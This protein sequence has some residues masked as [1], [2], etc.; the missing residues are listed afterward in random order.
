MKEF[1]LIRE[2]WRF[3]IKKNFFTSSQL[4]LF[5]TKISLLGSERISRTSEVH[6]ISIKQPTMLVIELKT[7]S[8]RKSIPL[9]FERDLKLCNANRGNH[10]KSRQISFNV[11][12]AWAWR[13]SCECNYRSLSAQL[14]DCSVWDKNHLF[15][16]FMLLKLLPFKSTLI[17]IGL[18][19]SSKHKKSILKSE[20][21]DQTK[22]QRFSI[23]LQT[24]IFNYSWKAF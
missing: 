11:T 20:S 3:L 5:T 14:S 10:L 16:L 17:L 1:L 19:S 4:C 22:A 24:I 21:F 9:Q 6:K 8:S 13:D 2:R 23:S 12:R 7:N 18:A 15:L